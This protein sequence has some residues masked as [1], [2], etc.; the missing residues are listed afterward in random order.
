MSVY[1]SL[2]FMCLKYFITIMMSMLKET[3]TQMELASNSRYCLFQSFSHIPKLTREKM[4][5]H[6]SN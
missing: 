2:Y 6:N 5:S 3:S 1:Y 4:K